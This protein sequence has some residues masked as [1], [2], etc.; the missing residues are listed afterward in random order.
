[1]IGVENLS[2][3]LLEFQN[4]VISNNGIL[5]QDFQKLDSQI[6]WAQQTIPIKGLYFN[7]EEQLSEFDMI[8]KTCAQLNER[9]SHQL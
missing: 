2:K 6:Q 8:E 5:G 7:Y 3:K 9:L 1:M 4:N